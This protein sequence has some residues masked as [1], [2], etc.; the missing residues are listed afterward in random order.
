MYKWYGIILYRMRTGVYD[1]WHTVGGDQTFV[2]KN[3]LTNTPD[4]VLVQFSVVLH[5]VVA[6]ATRSY[7]Q[8]TCGSRMHYI[9]SLASHKALKP[10]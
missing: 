7:G 2:V 5:S 6:L 1:V 10:D 8:R 3:P 4:L 9:S